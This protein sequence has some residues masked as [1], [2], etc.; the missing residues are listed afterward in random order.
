MTFDNVYEAEFDFVWRS[1][2]RLGVCEADAGDALQDVFFVVHR[3]LPEF[4]GRAKLSTWIFRI[5]MNVAR[6]RQRLVRASREVVDSDLLELHPVVARDPSELLED[7]E[8]LELLDQALSSMPLTQRAVFILFELEQMTR[9]EIACTLEIPLG[10][11]ASR[12]RLARESFRKS[13]RGLTGFEP[14]LALS[15]GGRR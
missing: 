12:L 14:A 13:M 9:E 4:A 3:R 1:L 5:C 6:A 2:R 8:A 10:T 7:Q 11:V 15:G